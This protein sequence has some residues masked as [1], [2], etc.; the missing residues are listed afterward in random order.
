M[1]NDDTVSDPQVAPSPWD[2]DVPS[3]TEAALW[4]SPRRIR[5]VRAKCAPYLA[6]LADWL[7]VDAIS[8]HS[9]EAEARGA[10]SGLGL[11]I[12]LS[13][14]ERDAAFAAEWAAARDA[15]QA[16]LR[17]VQFAVRPLVWQDA[18]GHRL[19][20]AAT[21][22]AHHAGAAFSTAQ[23]EH[24]IIDTAVP[25]VRTLARRRGKL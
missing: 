12:G 4:T 22:A 18:S 24:I 25:I 8:I 19:L 20:E 7:I 6:T 10:I 15:A 14:D 3:K 13:K 21:A 9:A 11:R 17:A 23:L 1:D 16:H 5:F 2:K